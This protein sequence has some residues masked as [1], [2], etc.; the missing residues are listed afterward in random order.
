[1]KVLE[2]ANFVF[3]SFALR[4]DK[5]EYKT[6]METIEKIVEDH[7]SKMKRGT[8]QLNMCDPAVMVG[9]NFFTTV[10]YYSYRPTPFVKTL[11]CCNFLITSVT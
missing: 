9:L 6:A 4:H 7:K 5:E 2:E 11:N 8:P 1:M 3:S 10:A